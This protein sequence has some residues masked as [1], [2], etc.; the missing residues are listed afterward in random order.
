VLVVDDNPLNRDVLAA[1]LDS[2]ALDVAFACDGREAVNLV[3]S[4]PRMEG[5]PPFELVFM[6]IQMPV[7]DGLDAAR[8][9]RHLPDPERARQPMV[10]MTAH[11][12]ERDRVDSLA[13]GMDDHLGKPIVPAQLDAVLR[14][15]CAP[16]AEG[17]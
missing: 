17:G 9:I 7:L 13:A 11:A 2:Y 1:Y 6:D 4:A 15:W 3:A 14:H 5:K 8:A 10:A 16:E 12:M